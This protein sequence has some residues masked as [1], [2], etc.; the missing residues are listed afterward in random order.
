MV[1]DLNIG[2]DFVSYHN[3]SYMYTPE[4]CNQIKENKRGVIIHKSKGKA[5]GVQLKGSIN[6]QIKI[7]ASPR[8]GDVMFLR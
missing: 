7:L 3:Q 6:S 4:P 1:D 5:S 8:R 2:K